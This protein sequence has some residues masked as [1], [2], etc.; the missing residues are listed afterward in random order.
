MAIKESNKE[1]QQEKRRRTQSEI[2]V[3][4]ESLIDSLIQVGLYDFG[5][6]LVLRTET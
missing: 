2:I 5:Q 3:G 6:A 4:S 1:E